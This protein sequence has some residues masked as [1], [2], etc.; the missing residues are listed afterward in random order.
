MP[1]FKYNQRDKIYAAN[2]VSLRSMLGVAERVEMI[3]IYNSKNYKLQ[4]H[5]INFHLSCSIL[6]FALVCLVYCKAIT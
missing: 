2:F 3:R 5:K 1:K 6:L 4:Q